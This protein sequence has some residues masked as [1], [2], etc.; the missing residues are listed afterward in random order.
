MKKRERI[1]L[2]AGPQTHADRSGMVRPE[3]RDE[4][5]LLTSLR[6]NHSRRPSPRRTQKM[7][8]HRG[9]WPP[10]WVRCPRCS[11]TRGSFCRRR[12]QWMSGAKTVVPM[13]RP[14]G[15]HPPPHLRFHQV[16][17]A[18]GLLT[19]HCYPFSHANSMHLFGTLP[20]TN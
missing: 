6:L 7:G 19:W 15:K 9:G 13:S 4:G 16:Q 12:D 8:C 17:G 1:T 3:G 20:N 10:S 18:R 11:R 14:P 5:H 2:G